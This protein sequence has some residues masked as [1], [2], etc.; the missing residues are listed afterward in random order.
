MAERVGFEPTL[1][2]RVNTLSKRAPSAT[3]PSLR[4]N[5]GTIA[6]RNAIA[7]PSRLQFTPTWLGFILWS[8]AH[9][10]K[11]AAPANKKSRKEEARFEQ[12]DSRR[13]DSKPKDRNRQRS[14]RV[15]AAALL[16]TRLNL[17]WLRPP[18]R[19]WLHRQFQERWEEPE[20]A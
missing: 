8:G 10:R 7:M 17:K 19:H 5:L 12:E 18:R 1:P 14:R 6:F 9:Q 13:K 15:F 4:R 11:S 20:V 3:R 16:W 2:F